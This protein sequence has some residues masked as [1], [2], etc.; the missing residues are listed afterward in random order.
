MTARA[1]FPTDNSGDVFGIFMSDLA[2]KSGFSMFVVLLILCS[3]VAAIMS[4]ADSCL[5]GLSNVFTQDVIHGWLLPSWGEEA[6]VKSGKMVSTVAMVI[7]LGW[8]YP[9]AEAGLGGIAA[10]QAGIG[11]NLIPVF[12]MGA[13]WPGHVYWEAQLLG[14]SVSLIF[15]LL[16]VLVFRSE[17]FGAAILSAAMVSLL[18]NII[19]TLVAQILLQYTRKTPDLVI[20]PPR[21]L[22][23]QNTGLKRFGRKLTQDD[24]KTIMDTEPL[25][26]PAAYKWIIFFVLLYFITLPWW[27][28]LPQQTNIIAGSPAWVFYASLALGVSFALWVYVMNTYWKPKDHENAHN[29]LVSSDSV[30]NLQEFKPSDASAPSIGTRAHIPPEV[31]REEISPDD[32]RIASK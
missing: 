21:K 31:S 12:I 32:F 20:D 7:A 14:M 2:T 17:S 22:Q 1:N 9:L 23:Y 25:T 8:S 11:A 13:F 26:S 10:I 27:S 15:L 18:T 6:L 16:L 29:D 30:L 24:I 5:I 4:T 19:L 28:F 3:A